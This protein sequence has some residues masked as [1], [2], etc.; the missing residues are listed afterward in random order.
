MLDTQKTPDKK[1]E[2]TKHTTH[3]KGELL[4]GIR[5]HPRRHIL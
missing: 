1:I 5:I 3:N 2:D 4:H